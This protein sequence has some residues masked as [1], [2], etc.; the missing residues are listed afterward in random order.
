VSETPSH[1]GRKLTELR[2]KAGLSMYRLAELIGVS[3]QAVSQM[4][5][6]KRG[7]S[8]ETVQRLALILKVDCSVFIDP[9][10][11]LPEAQPPGKA[12]RP[13]KGAAP[14]NPEGKKSKRK[15]G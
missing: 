2:E 12:G 15:G 13:R 10:L 3:H 9:D 8:W 1:F 4:E 5:S 11:P 6:G 14:E 7:P